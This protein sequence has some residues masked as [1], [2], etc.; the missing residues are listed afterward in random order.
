MEILKELSDI[1]LH[2]TEPEYRQRP[3][4]S[5]ST[6]STYQTLGFTGLDH[7]F[8][9]K[10]SPSLTLGSVCDSIL[11]GGED[12]FR[13]LYTV[14]DINVTDSGIDIC[15]NLIN[16]CLPFDT[17]EEIPE[18]LVSQAAK[19]IGFWQND[20]YDNSRYK[21]V[22]KCGN[23]AE[24]YNALRH[25]DKTIISNDT[26]QMALAMVR[27]LKES[28]ATSG[29]FADNDELS[30]VRRYYQLK[31]TANFEG[32]GYRNMADLLVV[33]Y[34]QKKVWPIDLKT[35]MSCVEW[36]FESNFKKW[37]Y[38]IQ[39]RLYWR[40]IRANMNKDDYFKDFSLEDYRFIICNPK[41]LTPLVWE[42][43][44]TKSVGTLITDDGEEIRDPFEIG[45]ELQGYL[46][47]RPPVPNGINKDGINIIKCLTKKQ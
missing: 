16:Q 21:Q 3:E 31:F 26:F 4:L 2:I 39:A 30:P 27:A 7:L 10:E 38:Y 35:S 40:I 43:P 24:Y 19:E 25:S 14:L 9:K 11:T 13:S 17:F 12:E 28:P 22:L 18:S 32:V 37:H 45:K 42:F 20:K 41:T 47:L 36:E 44:L 6:L 46:N 34:E 5:Y 29:Y 8:D 33:D 23:V 1:S 15:K